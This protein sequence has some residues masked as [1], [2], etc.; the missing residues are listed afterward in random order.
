MIGAPIIHV[1]FGHSGTTSLQDNIFSKRSDI[2]YAGI[3]HGELGGIFSWMKYLEPERYD[4]AETARLCDEL[5]FKKVGS[6]QRLV[7]SDE[8]FVEQPE[9]Y[10]TPPMMPVGIIAERLRAQFGESIVLFTLRDQ[11]RYVTSMYF[12]L[13][14]NYAALANRAIEPFDVWF[15]G[16]QNQER[17]LFLRNLDPSHAIKVYQNLFGAKSVHVLPLELLVRRGA[18]A[19]LDRLTEITGIPFTPDD[20]KHY[21]ARNVSPLHGL[22]LDDG[23]RATIRRHAAAANAF[24]AT[25]FGLPLR[26]FGYPLPD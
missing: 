7:V 20:A 3:P 19:Y 15:A 18:Q 4:Q 22:V 25:E 24:V 9:V 12:N 21:V 23:Q 10:Y 16:N 17:N 13:K 6:D 1:G 2:F 11:M 8:C 26:E 5:I 14:K